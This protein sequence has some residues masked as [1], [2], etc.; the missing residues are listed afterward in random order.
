ME[1]AVAPKRAAQGR[2][3]RYIS[4]QDR[5]DDREFVID[6]YCVRIWERSHKIY[7]KTVDR[8]P[9]VC[10]GVK[11]REARFEQMFSLCSREQTEPIGR[12][13]LYRLSEAA[14]AHRLSESAPFSC[15]VRRTSE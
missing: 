14:D 3:L 8:A 10:S 2:R 11:L 6:Q 13:K 9:V 5:L 1:R 15:L 4:W 7:D 12:L